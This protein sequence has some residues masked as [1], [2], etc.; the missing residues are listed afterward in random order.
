MLL[1]LFK[2]SFSAKRIGKWLESISDEELLTSLQQV[3]VE[4]SM[5]QQAVDLEL[6]S[7]GGEFGARRTLD[8]L[9]SSVCSVHFS[10]IPIEA[11]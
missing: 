3:Y 9:P 10:N 4:L 11:A 5:V 1:N 7:E 2:F 6:C 8:V